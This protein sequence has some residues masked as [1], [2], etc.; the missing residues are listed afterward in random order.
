MLGL[1]PKRPPKSAAQK[2]LGPVWPF[3]DILLYPYTRTC[4]RKLLDEKKR[5]QNYTYTCFYR[6]PAQLEAL[7]SRIIPWLTG[8]DPAQELII[9][10]FACSTGAEVYT[11]ASEITRVHP[12][13]PFTIYASDLHD[14]TVARGKAATYSPAEAFCNPDIPDTFITRTFDLVDSQLVVKPEIRAK[15]E[16]TRADLLDPALA[17]H[18]VPA[19]IV[20]AQNVF[21]HLDLSDAATA[22]TNVLK[23]A[24]PRSALLIDGMQLD[25]KEQLT[26]EAGLAPLDF[27]FRE[28]YSES[29]K[30]GRKRWWQGYCGLEPILPWQRNPPRRYGTVFLRGASQNC[31]T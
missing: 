31:Q 16:F 15:V 11:L 5:K 14:E 13:I 28:I 30:H 4:F 3:L 22:F 2:L 18:F 19:D 12:H 27:K 6:L 29:R 1:R 8:G 26:V 7:T 10:V 21:F 17:K 24:K 25:L 23:T 9:N 20:L